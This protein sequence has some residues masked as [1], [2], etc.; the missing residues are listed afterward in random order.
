MIVLLIQRRGNCGDAFLRNG[1]RENYAARV[2]ACLVFD[3]AT[4]ID[5]W[6]A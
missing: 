6:H 4:V 2:V 3:A 5:P 1:R